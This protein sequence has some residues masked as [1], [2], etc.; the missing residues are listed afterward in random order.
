M[1]DWSWG[2]PGTDRVGKMGESERGS[3]W[4]LTDLEEEPEASG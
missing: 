2:S 1:G 3:E 4:R